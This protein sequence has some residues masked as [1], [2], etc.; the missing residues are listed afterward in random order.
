[1][2]TQNTA[3]TKANIH[4]P[5]TGVVGLILLLTGVNSGVGMC[6]YADTGQDGR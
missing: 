1:M 3:I 2:D 5:F 6:V 4:H